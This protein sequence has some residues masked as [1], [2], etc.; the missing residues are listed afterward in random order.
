MAVFTPVSLEDVN[1]WLS[2]NYQ[3]GTATQIKGI[4]SGIENSNF[5]LTTEKNGK[6]TEYVL[7]LFERLSKEQLPYYLELMEHLAIKGIRVP[8]PVRDTQ[9]NI[10]GFL[11]GK[12]AT[13]VSRL[14][15]VSRLQPQLEHCEAVGEMLAK[16]HLAGQDFHLT[17]PNLRS[18]TWWQDTIPQIE[19]HLNADQKSLIQSELNDQTAFFGS[20]VYA[21]LP[22]GPSHCD[23]FRDNVLFDPS[24]GKDQL[25][26]FFDFYF[27][28]NDKWLFD[29]A[30]TVNDWCIDLS[31]GQIDTA[32]YTGL[33]KQY[34]LM[35]PLSQAEQASWAMMLRAAALRFWVSRLWDFY[36]PREAQMLTPHDPTHFERILRE[37]RTNTPKI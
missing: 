31:T 29:L 25:G 21:Q 3:L 22:A 8:A 5:F 28:G 12:P 33:L 10:L 15:G 9:A 16:M 4:N 11:N 14:A 19:S 20:D 2:Q 24:S 6:T 17:Q 26:G 30:V 34:Q 32:R 18:L 13:I 1:T 27:A 37:R 23:L 35:R 7:T 36:L